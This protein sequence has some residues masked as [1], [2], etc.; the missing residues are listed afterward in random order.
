MNNILKASA[1]F[2]AGMLSSSIAGFT[3]GWAGYD[4]DLFL[5]FPFI[6]A[7]FIIAISTYMAKV[8]LY[9]NRQIL[10]VI[11]I[12]FGAT[13]YFMHVYG[14]YVAFAGVIRE[15]ILQVPQNRSMS[16]TELSLSVYRLINEI[17]RRKVGIAGPIGWVI[18]RMNA[19]ISPFYSSNQAQA[20]YIAGA[21]V[22]MFKL[23][24]MT[25]VTGIALR[26]LTGTLIRL[27]K[28]E[29]YQAAIK[30]REQERQA[31]KQAEAKSFRIVVAITLAIVFI[32]LV[33]FIISL[34]LY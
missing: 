23:G 20:S 6:V 33:L 22:E 2:M 5:V 34:Y 13:A 30:Q 29:A 28:D 18:F 14:G 26:D 17:L 32:P 3:Y 24:S 4:F 21:L 12:I 19:S 11:G 1:I 25:T 9:E 7:A 10:F 15:Q 27:E 8:L 16:S 31:E